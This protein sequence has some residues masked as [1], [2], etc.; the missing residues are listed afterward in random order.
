MMLGDLVLVKKINVDRTVN[1]LK[2]A[3]SQVAS[4][5]KMQAD[6][7]AK[8]DRAINRVEHIKQR[9]MLLD[10]GNQTFVR[11]M[12]ELLQLLTI[13]QQDLVVLRKALA[14]ADAHLHECD[15]QAQKVRDEYLRADAALALIYDLDR[16]ELRRR[17]LIL[18]ESAEIELTESIRPP[19]TRKR[20]FLTTRVAGEK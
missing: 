15:Q 20:K 2:D 8:L 7:K 18:A 9:A 5:L 4:A 13:L 10:T 1:A 19:V 3:T 16:S 11:Q 17:D 14:A 12:N 6:T